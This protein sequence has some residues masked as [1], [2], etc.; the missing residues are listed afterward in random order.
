MVNPKTIGLRQRKRKPG[1][2]RLPN[3]VRHIY[4]KKKKTEVCSFPPRDPKT[5]DCWINMIPKYPKSQPVFISPPGPGYG[6]LAIAPPGGVLGPA[7]IA[8]ELNDS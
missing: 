4:L 6:R 8:L 7:S 5:M 1:K 3:T 2:K